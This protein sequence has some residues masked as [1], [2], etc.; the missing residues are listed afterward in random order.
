MEATM[1]NGRGETCTN[2]YGFR[3]FGMLCPRC[4]Y[5]DRGRSHIRRPPS[6]NSQ[7]SVVSLVRNN[8]QVNALTRISRGHA[9]VVHGQALGWAPVDAE[10]APDAAT[11]VDDHGGGVRAEL[12]AGHLRQ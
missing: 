5:I 2:G 10:S 4:V 12:T 6:R 1:E 8:R 9:E 11:L 7:C 3:G